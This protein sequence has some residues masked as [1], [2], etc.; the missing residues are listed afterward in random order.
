MT[1]EA[2]KKANKKYEQTSRITKRV[3]FHAVRDAELL[4]FAN[5][6]DDFSNFVKNIL[7]DK[8]KEKEN[9]K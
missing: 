3:S 7:K 8:M 4:E 1:S 2:Q 5:N 9:S 6:L